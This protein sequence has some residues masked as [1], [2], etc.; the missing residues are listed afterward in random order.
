MSN[1]NKAIIDAVRL[2]LSP[3]RMGTYEAAAGVT[4]GDDP[5]A[6]ALYAWNADVSGALLAPLHVCEVVVRNA[7]SDALEAVYG[8]RWPWS[9]TFERSLP[10]PLRGYSP[11]KDLQS[12]RRSAPTTGKVIPELKFVF[13]QKMFTQRHD[14]RIWDAHL[15]RIMPN[16]DGSKTVAELR[17]EIY[18]DL[19][20]IRGLRNRIAHH[21]PIFSRSLM[22]DYQKILALVRFR[23]GSTA[24]WLEENQKATAVIAEKP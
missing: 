12:A 2:A 16:L 17:Q 11:R 6:L 20:Q 4:G 10:D 13:W 8:N 14:A 22:D 5:S 21:E 9:A 24:S 3:A 15:M 18:S 19:E 23:C 1:N 7:V